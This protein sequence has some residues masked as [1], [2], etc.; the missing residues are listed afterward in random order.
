MELNIKKKK[1][2]EMP[3]IEDIT[4]QSLLMVVDGDINYKYPLENITGDYVK[5]LTSIDNHIVVDNTDPQNPTLS[6]QLVDNENLLT[7]DELAVVQD[8]S[9]TNTGDQDLS[10]LQTKEDSLLETE[11]TNIVEAINEVNAIAKGAGNGRVFATVVALDAWLAIPENIALLKIGDAFYIV[12]LDVPDYWWDGT[13][14]QK[15]ETQ[16]VD[17]SLYYTSEEIDTI[18]SGKQDIL[19]FATKEEAEAGISEEDVMSPKTTKDAINYNIGTSTQTALDLKSNLTRTVALS[20][21]DI[22][23]K[24]G[25]DFT[26]L[27]GMGANQVFTLNNAGIVLKKSFRLFIT[28]GSIPTQPFTGYTAIWILNS[29]NTDYVPASTNILVGEVRAAGTIH[30]FWSE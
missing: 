9:G 29:L 16:K 20:A 2:S 15:L 10:G 27:T 19:S 26:K 21:F 5:S 28:G 24:D 22:V 13:Q 12:Q 17:L 7:D 14:K 8:T 18:L 4:P 1:V 25:E 30:L 3:L 6:F 11:S 23:L